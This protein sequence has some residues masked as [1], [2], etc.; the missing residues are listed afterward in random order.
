MKEHIPKKLP[1]K[2]DIETKKI[3]KATTSD[4]RA[5]AELKS[6]GY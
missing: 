6:K 4:H 5:L 1:L 2:K 3:L